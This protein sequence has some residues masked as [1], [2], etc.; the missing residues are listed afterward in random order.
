ML[1]RVVERRVLRKKKI[2]EAALNYSG[3]KWHWLKWRRD[4][5]LSCTIPMCQVN[6]TLCPKIHCRVCI[7]LEAIQSAGI[8]AKWKERW[9]KSQLMMPVVHSQNECAV[10]TRFVWISVPHGG[11]RRPCEITRVRTSCFASTISWQVD[12]N[13]RLFWL[14]C[15]FSTGY[16]HLI[17]C[18]CLVPKGSEFIST[19]SFPILCCE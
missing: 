4:R 12:F 6:H 10:A 17:F 5:L 15:Y 8:K 11:L 1:V 13:L 3:A 2:W 18:F 9:C 16:F 7:D 14:L 19:N